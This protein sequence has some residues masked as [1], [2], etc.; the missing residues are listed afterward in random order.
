VNQSIELIGNELRALRTNSIKMSELEQ[1]KSYVK[2]NMILG[3]ESSARRMRKIGEAEI[4]GRAHYSLDQVLAK[5]E[6]I[7]PRDLQELAEHFF[8]DSRLCTT[9]ISPN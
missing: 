5:I 1:V 2:G 7:K 3:L 9:I 8:D 6:K 4:Y